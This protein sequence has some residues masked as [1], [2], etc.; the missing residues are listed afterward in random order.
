MSAADQS[1]TDFADPAFQAKVSAYIAADDAAHAAWLARG[2]FKT[3]IDEAV[4]A[5]R[6]AWNANSE[7]PSSDYP[8]TLVL[9]ELDHR[10]A[11][12]LIQAL[13]RHKIGRT[14]I[15]SYVWSI[16][17]WDLMNISG[18][19]WAAMGTFRQQDATMEAFAL[20]L[21]KPGFELRIQRE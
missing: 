19:Y 13:S 5:G 18:S 8:D 15:G 11:K 14:D 2:D 3:L 9:I 16:G 20:A 6:A 4:E 7:L 12:P 21:S 17:P 1:E 10:R